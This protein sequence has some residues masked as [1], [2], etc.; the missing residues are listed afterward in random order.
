[1]SFILLIYTIYRDV[2]IKLRKMEVDEEKKRMLL[3][4]LAGMTAI[5]ISSTAGSG[6]LDI[7]ILMMFVSLLAMTALLIQT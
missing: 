4:L 6:F 3:A 7:L 2:F 5:L 1:M